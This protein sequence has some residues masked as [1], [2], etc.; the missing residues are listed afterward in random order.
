LC[1]RPCPPGYFE[2]RVSRPNCYGDR[3]TR[4]EK[5]PIHPSDEIGAVNSTTQTQALD[6][7]VVALVVLGL[8]VVEQTPALADELQQAAARMMILRVALEVL[9]EIG[10]A[11]AQDR[12]LDFRRTGVALG[13]G[14]RLDQL[15]LADGCDRH[16]DSPST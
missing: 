13:L 7:C 9:G 1:S 11:L 12:D 4:R 10:D 5:A 15:R 14:V 16:R 8:E 3:T 2:S 6:Q